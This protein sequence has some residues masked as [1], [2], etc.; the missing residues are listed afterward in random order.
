MLFLPL[1]IGWKRRWWQRNE[2]HWRWSIPC[3]AGML[4]VSDYL[5]FGALRDPDALV[6]VVSSVRRGSTLIAFAGGLLLFREAN[7]LRK[8]PAVLGVLAGIVL[9]V[10]ARPR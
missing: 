6:S 9:I 2:F 10:L 7:G 4:L 3:I 8:L 1:A 5:Y